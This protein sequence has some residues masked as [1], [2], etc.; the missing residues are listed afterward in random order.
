[1]PYTVWKGCTFMVN[2][3]HKQPSFASRIDA[4]RRGTGYDVSKDRYCSGLAVGILV[5]DICSAHP[6]L[7]SPPLAPQLRALGDT[8]S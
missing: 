1:M 7:L 8:R 2:E 3:S 6:N 5:N 4:P